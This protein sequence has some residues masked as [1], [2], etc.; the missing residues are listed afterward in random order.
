MVV[1]DLAD[2]IKSLLEVSITSDQRD[3]A[4]KSV[5]AGFRRA[6]QPLTTMRVLEV[7]GPALV[8]TSPI[9]RKR[10]VGLL[11]QIFENV[12][13]LQLS[14]SD[15][16]SILKFMILKLEDWHCIDG[17]VKAL[18]FL[19][20]HHK[21]TAVGLTS[22]EHS[23]Q[24]FV[25]V[26]FAKVIK[27]VHAP[28]YAQSLRQSVL[29]LLAVLLQEFDDEIITLGADVVDGVIHEC[30]DERDPRNLK[31]M[32][33]LMGA[34]V[35]QYSSLIS[36]KKVKEIGDMLFAYWPCA[37]EES[38]THPVSPVELNEC[39]VNVL[40]NE[41]LVKYIMELLVHNAEDASESDSSRKDAVLLLNRFFNGFDPAFARSRIADS[42]ILSLFQKCWEQ[43]SQDPK[44][45]HGPEQ[46]NDFF[47]AVAQLF[48]TAVKSCFSTEEL[49]STACD[50][51]IWYDECCKSL[52]DRL[53]D[54][55]MKPIVNKSV[56]SCMQMGSRAHISILLI[57][58]R[59]SVWSVIKTACEP[60]D[61][62]YDV[63]MDK[64]RTNHLML[65]HRGA[66][67]EPSWPIQFKNPAG[68][69]QNA[70]LKRITA[71]Q[72]ADEQSSIFSLVRSC[73][74]IDSGTFFI[75]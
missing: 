13:E 65:S 20:R 53:L 72:N 69:L 63:F 21:S 17:A 50:P 40:A 39:L 43:D 47:D 38:P 56:A 24:S 5:V 45:F 15:L 26:I 32:F 49:S 37:F 22:V 52:V 11:A 41:V 73:V 4:F 16:S 14:K 57:I 30:D 70:L 74:E 6:E 67:H 68:D 1:S 34:L 3:V 59:S 7:L 29:E 18:L 35:Q 48:G 62:S 60:S 61:L 2:E 27:H 42:F 31:V 75:N 71:T 54:E 33:P 28:S 44:R 46:R 66:L 8:D 51:P 9:P 25:C 12:P 19:L 64:L 55:G 36:D 23:D 58:W 10:A